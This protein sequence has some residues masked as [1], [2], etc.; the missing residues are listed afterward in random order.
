MGGAMIFNIVYYG[1]LI[2]TLQ[3]DK[4][5][6]ARTI[7]NSTQTVDFEELQVE[8]VKYFLVKN[9]TDGAGDAGTD[10]TK[11][12]AQSNFTS[13]LCFKKQISVWPQFW[14][15]FTRIWIT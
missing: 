1:Y 11:Y 6:V 15:I 10:L 2:S 7:F 9:N 4:Y 12:I 3:K 8:E 14:F 5:Y 13:N